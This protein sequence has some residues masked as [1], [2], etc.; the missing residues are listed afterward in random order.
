[1]ICKTFLRGP[2]VFFLHAKHSEVLQHVLQK[3]GGGCDDLQQFDH[4]KLI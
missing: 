4:L 1:M 2:S 3:R